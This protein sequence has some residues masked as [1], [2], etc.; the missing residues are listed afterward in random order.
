MNKCN[1]K[2]NQKLKQNFGRYKD[3]LMQ[4][5]NIRYTLKGEHVPVLHH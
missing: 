5:L 1:V 4:P 3:V 2:Q